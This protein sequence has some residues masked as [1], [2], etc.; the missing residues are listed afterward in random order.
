MM[1]LGVSAKMMWLPRL[2]MVMR[3]IL[4]GVAHVL[5]SGSI[6]LLYCS[7]YDGRGGSFAFVML[8]TATGIMLFLPPAPT[9]PSR[10]GT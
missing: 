2:L 10:R 7:F 9:M 6:L 3:W 1:S 5:G 4:L 8:A